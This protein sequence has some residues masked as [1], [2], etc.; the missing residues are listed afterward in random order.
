MALTYT[1]NHSRYVL[2]EALGIFQDVKNRLVAVN[3]TILNFSLNFL[4]ISIYFWEYL[5]V[6]FYSK[7][8]K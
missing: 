5:L 6:T 3:L 1:L 7:L 2:P 8:V 4:L